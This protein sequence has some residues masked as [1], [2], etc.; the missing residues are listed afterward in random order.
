[1]KITV[2][3]IY[4]VGIQTPQVE[5]P[6][7][8]PS[9]I[10]LL[11]KDFPTITRRKWTGIQPLDLYR[12]IDPSVEFL[13]YR[14]RAPHGEDSTADELGEVCGM[15]VAEKRNG[16][17]L[18]FHVVCLESLTAFNEAHAHATLYKKNLLPGQ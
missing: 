7:I 4:A 18:S 1:M 14:L 6:Q 5:T 8:T 2:A 10:D 17:G 3:E 13:D 16:S 9:Q 15:C 11:S 12:L